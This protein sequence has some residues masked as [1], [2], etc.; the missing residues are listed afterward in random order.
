[1]SAINR[2]SEF[3]LQELNVWQQIETRHSCE[4]KRL[5]TFEKGADRVEF[6]ANEIGESHLG[7]LVRN[8]ALQIAALDVLEKQWSEH[9][10]VLYG[11]QID[12]LEQHSSYSTLTLSFSLELTESKQDIT[13]I[14][15]D[16][17]IGADGAR[18][19]I[20]Q[21]ANIGS[22]GWDYQQACLSVTVKSQFPR[23]DITWQEFQPSG[24]K[25]FLPM[26]D[27][28]AC[29][30]WYDA[31]DVVADLSK[32]SNQALKDQIL[33]TYSQLPGDFEI[34][35]KASFPLRRN[36]ANQY[37]KNRVVLVGDAAHTINPLAG[38][39]VNLGFKDNQ[40][41]LTE[42]A[43]INDWSNSSDLTNALLA[44]EKMQKLESKVMSAAMDSFYHLFSNDKSLLKLARHALLFATNKLTT[45][46]KSV[47]KKALGF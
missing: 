36:Q 33:K 18:S 21:L 16:L 6:S 12:A 37:F 11:A 10:D 35:R 41:L 27:G 26:N 25:A 20:R 5:A 1:M 23:Q 13:T 32:L 42:L 9:V 40:R 15:A 34:V 4:F 2:N 17:I 46:K 28:F 30:I 39:G 7:H 19:R 45:I 29:L 38:Q 24:P 8:E 47:M 3:W 44:Y 43:K 14:S 22:T 31:K